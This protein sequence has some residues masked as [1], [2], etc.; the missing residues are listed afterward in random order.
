MTYARLSHA[1][2]AELVRTTEKG[3]TP[4][5]G[6][7]LTLPMFGFRVEASPLFPMLNSCGPCN[8]TGEGGDLTTY[9]PRCHGAGE[10]QTDG[11]VMDGRQ[12]TLIVTKLPPKFAPYFPRDIAVP[13][14]KVPGI[15]SV[16]W[17]SQ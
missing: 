16:D 5:P 2:Y 4:L 14:R 10:V 9:C 12:T 17:P 6:S 15:V 11:V 8:G 13:L 7:G 3:G 1:A